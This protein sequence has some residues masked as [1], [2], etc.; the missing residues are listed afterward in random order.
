LEEFVLRALEKAAL[1]KQ[2][3]AEIVISTIWRMQVHIFQVV[4][5]INQR[6]HREDT[7]S[8]MVAMN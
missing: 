4:S 5:L 7:N 3:I 6:E 1:R 2:K 8:W